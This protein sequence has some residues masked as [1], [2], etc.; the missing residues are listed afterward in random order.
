MCSC[1]VHPRH[2]WGLYIQANLL[3][4][5]I[6]VG[7]THRSELLRCR[8]GS[9]TASSL[10]RAP[11]TSFYTILASVQPLHKCTPTFAQRSHQ[12]LQLHDIFQGAFL[13]QL[14][15]YADSLLRSVPLGYQRRAVTFFWQ[16]ARTTWVHR[17]STYFLSFAC[18]LSFID[19]LCLHCQL[20][21]TTRLP[22]FLFPWVLGLDENPDAGVVTINRAIYG[23]PKHNSFF[24]LNF[25]N[26][27]VHADRKSV[28]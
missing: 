22:K 10:D 6:G 14:S 1:A 20:I 2:R 3:P 18:C 21:I 26:P 11:S 15:R 25:R 9:K 28:V 13:L 16:A 4:G 8:V 27:K 12:C 5:D 24:L 19:E 7:S 17:S 23:L